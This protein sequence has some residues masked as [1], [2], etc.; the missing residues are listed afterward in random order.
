[1]LLFNKI[2]PQLVLPFGIV[3]LLLLLAVWKK[4]GWPAV[5]A[6]LV[7]YAASIP[8]VG[9]RLIGWL[10]G[11][12]APMAMIEAGP[13]DA[14]VVLGGIL[15][16]AH[17]D[18]YMPNRSEQGERFDAGV[19]LVLAGQAQRLVFTG[20]RRHWI[21]GETTEGD[22]LERLAISHGVPAEKIFV[23]RVVDNTATEATAV[24]ELMIAQGWKRVILVTS[25]WH[26]PR[27]MLLFR[28]AGV[29]AQPF[30]VDLRRGEP[31]RPEIIDF[32][33]SAVAW[34]TTETAL[35]ECYGYAF[36]RITR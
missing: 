21:D 17:R 23:T 15:G 8:F 24:A 35:R 3:M 4:Q 7:L 26:L 10:E 25:G 22:Q 18:G 19:A 29:V 13:A 5:T 12:Y 2:L 27:A 14:V 6:M 28:R 11:Q 33:P 20:A 34:Q 36:Y 1:M 32:V 30:P 31:R 9:D 16:P